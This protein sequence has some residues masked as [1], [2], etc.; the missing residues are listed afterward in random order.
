MKRKIILTT[1]LLLS[2]LPCLRGQRKEMSQARSY[3][4]SGKDFDKAEKLMED[5]VDKA[6][7]EAVGETSYQRYIYPKDFF[8]LPADAEISE[9]YVWFSNVDGSVISKDGEDG[10]LLSQAEQ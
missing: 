10:T 1:L 2:V 6:L 7:M 8:G 5:K 9:I 3:L 4:K